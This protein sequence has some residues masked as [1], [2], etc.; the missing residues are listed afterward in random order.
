[1]AENAPHH[2]KARLHKAVARYRTARKT[3]HTPASAQSPRALDWMNFFLADVQT[4]FGAFVAFYLARLGWTERNV[5]IVLT[6]GGLAGVLSQLPG[7]ALADAVPWK[8][9]LTAIGIVAIGIAALI[10]ALTPNYFAV[11]AAVLLQGGTGG[12]VTPAIGA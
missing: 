9:G 3:L 8:S 4:A 7:G 5:G 10:L 6:V 12:I 2:H 1:M 11:M